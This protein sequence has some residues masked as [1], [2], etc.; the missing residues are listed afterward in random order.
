MLCE[1]CAMHFTFSQPDLIQRILDTKKFA[2]IAAREAGMGLTL[3]QNL[4]QELERYKSGTKSKS[5]SA[6]VSCPFN[7]HDCNE[8][9]I[10]TGRG[11]LS[12]W[13][14]SPG[15]GLDQLIATAASDKCQM[16][17][18]IVS[19]VGYATLGKAP[20]SSMVESV[21]YLDDATCRPTWLLIV[22]SHFGSRLAKLSFH[23]GVEDATSQ[24]VVVLKT[25]VATSTDQEACMDFC[26]SSLQACLTKHEACRPKERNLWLPTRLLDLHLSLTDRGKV[27]VIQT[28]KLPEN[29]PRQ[30][31]QYVTLSHSW[32]QLMPTK[33]SMSNMSC[34]EEGIR[35]IDLPL[36]FR[37]AIRVAQRLK[38]HYL[39]IDSLCPGSGPLASACSHI[40]SIIQDSLDDR[41][42]ECSK[43][44]K[45]YRHSVCNISACDGEDATASLFTARNPHYVAPIVFTQ[46][47][48]DCVMQFSVIPDHVNLARS[49]SHLFTRGW[50]FQE[51]L[52]CPRM[53]YF[54]HFVAWEC[55][56]C[57]TTEIYD[58]SVLPNTLLFPLLPESERGWVFT[59][60]SSGY[61]SHAAR[62]WKLVRTYTD[63]N[64]TYPN[65]KLIAVS[66]LARQ[67]SKII[68]KPY[69]AG[70]WGGADV[71]LSLL[72]Y[73]SPIASAERIPQSEYRAPSWSWASADGVA[74]Y[75]A[76]T[77]DVFSHISNLLIHIRSISTEPKYGDIFGE[78]KAGEL[79]LTGFVIELQQLRQPNP[80]AIGG[81]LAWD[82]RHHTKEAT[83]YFIPFGEIQWNEWRDNGDGRVFAGILVQRYPDFP[84]SDGRQ[85]FQRVGR[86]EFR[87]GW[88]RGD[89]WIQLC[90][91]SHLELHEQDLI[92]V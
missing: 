71:V 72:W 64:L 79:A 41:A 24:P 77:K 17:Q 1:S 49:H 32:G 89:I 29:Q 91:L 13:T 80:H 19:M 11:S 47:Y 27:R 65:D 78:V 23:I 18:T 48:T 66:G 76:A 68:G 60:E 70:I 42:K 12:V 16:C 20:V 6:A 54:A 59:R 84:N 56:T 44:H 37:D 4:A 86:G 35:I 40:S 26:S 2:V 75:N 25:P 10:Y 92:I 73:S 51:R 45:V 57:V 14:N 34:M 52:L 31:V 50:V 83:T 87:E 74:L 58:E 90:G 33:L 69:Y 8:Y 7:L 30:D 15:R 38:I 39:W 63:S 81:N 3:I 88:G 36:R 28:E 21:L 67:F 9:K 22:V 5:S 46:E 61:P 55:R 43:M 62:W 82:N 85:I 53:I